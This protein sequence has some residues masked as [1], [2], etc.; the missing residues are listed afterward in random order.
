M[1]K[2]KNLALIQELSDAPGA[3]GFEDEVLDV[4]RRHGEGLG[5][6]KEDAM[7]NLYLRRPDWKEGRPVLMVDAHSDEVGFLIR[8]IRS[9]GTLDFIT[10]GG[11]VPYCVPAHKVRVRNN[12]G[13]WIPGIISSKP[14]HYLS[15]SERKQTPEISDM[16]IDLGASSEKEI[17][18]EYHISIAA[19]V[20]PD[21]VFE[22]RE[23]HGIMIGKAF[24]CRLG[25][26][27]MVSTFR[28]LAADELSVNLC[29]AFSVQEEM[30]LRGA[31]VTAQTVK[32][33]I[34]IVFEG[35]PADDTF[36][37]PAS[38]QTALKKGPMLR[39][40]DMRMITNPRFQRFALNTAREKGIPVQEAIRTGGSTDAGMI[41]TTGKAVPVI[42][43]S[44]PTRYIHTHY[45]ISAYSDYENA[46]RLACAVI[47]GLDENVIMGF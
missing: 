44:V 29:G 5:E 30:G 32:P 33:D 7:R 1:D 23:N 38:A 26:A 45:S 28:E 37:D 22:Y 42:V 25:C 43:I 47:R 35:S 9:N 4:I 15:E 8:N 39:H 18:E 46:V 36:G 2:Q 3:P 34:A 14:P 20:V 17:R 12:K 27:A 16:V 41:H 10:L 24:D 21:V 6:W 11:W 13:E 31:V 40:F 19:P